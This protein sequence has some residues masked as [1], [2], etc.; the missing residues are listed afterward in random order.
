LGEFSV[1]LK[2]K[3]QLIKCFVRNKWKLVRAN[4]TQEIKINIKWTF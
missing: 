2:K 1:Q 3:T 4:L